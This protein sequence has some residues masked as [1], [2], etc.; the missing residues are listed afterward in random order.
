MSGAPTLPPTDTPRGMFGRTER[1]VALLTSQVLAQQQDI[2]ELKEVLLERGGVHVGRFSRGANFVT[3]PG[4]M[5]G[6]MPTSGEFF[7]AATGDTAPQGCKSGECAASTLPEEWRHSIQN[8]VADILE[9]YLHQ[10]D[11]QLANILVS[12]LRAVTREHVARTFEREARKVTKERLQN[13]APHCRTKRRSSSR[14]TKSSG[15]QNDSNNRAHFASSLDDTAASAPSGPPR[16]KRTTWGNCTACASSSGYSAK[17][18][19]PLNGQQCASCPGLA[20]LEPYASTVSYDRSFMDSG[21][22]LLPCFDQLFPESS[23]RS[24]NVTRADHKRLASHSHI[25]RRSSPSGIGGR[26]FSSCCHILSGEHHDSGSLGNS[27]NATNAS[28][29]VEVLVDVF[30][31]RK[32]PKEVKRL[33]PWE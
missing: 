11:E 24:H 30:K 6:D 33:I 32:P 20:L 28:D 23:G 17:T 29:D 4:G 21:P 19:K 10:V 5:R 31:G 9:L 3:E 16:D 15:R 1:I 2:K 18:A 27:V 8:Y 25:D 7:S 26:D 13:V 22:S 14:T 12:R